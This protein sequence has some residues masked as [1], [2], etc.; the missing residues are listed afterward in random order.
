VTTQV[1]EQVYGPGRSR[2]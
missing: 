2:R 1:K